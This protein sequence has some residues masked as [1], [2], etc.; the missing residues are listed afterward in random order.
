MI[1]HLLE[2]SSL[3]QFQYSAIQ[4]C[5]LK[6][7]QH[8]FRQIISH[9]QRNIQLEITLEYELISYCLIKT[10]VD[11]HHKNPKNR[12]DGSIKRWDIDTS[13]SLKC[14][15]VVFNC[16]ISYRRFWH[17][18]KS[19]ISAMHN[20]ISMCIFNRK[21]IGCKSSAAWKKTQL[22]ISSSSGLCCFHSQFKINHIY[23]LARTC[24]P[25]WSLCSR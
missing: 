18:N 2:E 15:L 14:L 6:F 8:L 16:K 1:I 3:R 4:I 13:C 21:F 7:T 20:D 9:R 17:R 5:I 25:I 22:E 23:R 19:Y 11:L 24:P 10:K 12:H